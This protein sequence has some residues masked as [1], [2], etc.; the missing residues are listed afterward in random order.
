MIPSPGN[1]MKSQT[2]DLLLEVLS[3]NQ[4]PA[5]HLACENLKCSESWNIFL[6]DIKILPTTYLRSKCYKN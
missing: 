5:T 1:L 4:H 6:V 2:L 3:S